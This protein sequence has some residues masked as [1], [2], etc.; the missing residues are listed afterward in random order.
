MTT[1]DRYFS[2]G[3]RLDFESGNYLGGAGTRFYDPENGRKLQPSANMWQSSGRG[4]K[5]K[6]ALN[7]RLGTELLPFRTIAPRKA[8]YVLRGTRAMGGWIAEP[9]C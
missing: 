8:H 1:F 7:R 2:E 6:F 9:S 3:R 4:D 5:A